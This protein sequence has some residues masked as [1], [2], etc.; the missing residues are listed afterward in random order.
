MK[1]IDFNIKIPKEDIFNK[2]L[3]K[4]ENP[5]LYARY[6]LPPTKESDLQITINWLGNLIENALNGTIDPKTGRSSKT[7]SMDVQRK[8]NKVMNKVDE[9]ENGIVTMEDDDFKFLNRKYHQGEVPIIRDIN[10]I[11]VPLSDAIKRA[12]IEEKPEEK[13]KK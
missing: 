12:D 10:K 11:L 7:S 2:V 5:K 4:K 3:F 1:K 6:L 13:K 8:Y 9:N